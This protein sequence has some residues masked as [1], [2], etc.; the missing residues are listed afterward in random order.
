MVEEGRQRANQWDDAATQRRRAVPSSVVLADEATAT[1]Q[2]TILSSSVLS[3]S[4]DLPLPFYADFHCKH[5]TTHPT[6]LQSFYFSVD[7][8]WYNDERGVVQCT[9]ADSDSERQVV[10]Y[11]TD[12]VNYFPTGAS[13]RSLLRT[14]TTIGNT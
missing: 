5:F 13:L 1:T 6:V 12:S 2:C 3:S 4:P 11:I 8:P 14:T 7:I 9:W 10:V